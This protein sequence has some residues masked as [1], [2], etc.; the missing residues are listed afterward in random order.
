MLV[1]EQ[2]PQF[3]R[4]CDFRKKL[5]IKKRQLK[6]HY[7]LNKKT[8][9]IHVWRSMRNLNKSLFQR[10]SKKFPRKIYTDPEDLQLVLEKNPRSEVIE[11]KS[12][13]FIGSPWENLR[14][15]SK[16]SKNIESGFNKSAIIVDL[17]KKK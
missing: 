10:F 2:N 13:F 16:K 12:T 1:L 15:T 6:F 3:L 5:D 4:T 14:K 11:D 7:F 8:L 17:I 9:K